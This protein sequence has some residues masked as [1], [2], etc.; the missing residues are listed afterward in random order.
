MNNF[1]LTRSSLCKKSKL[2]F[3]NDNNRWCRLS[4]IVI[5]ALDVTK[6]PSGP[7]YS[8]LCRVRF[9]SPLPFPH[10]LRGSE[11]ERGLVYRA[12][13]RNRVTETATGPHTI[14]AANLKHGT[15]HAFEC[16]GWLCPATF[17]FCLSRHQH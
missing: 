7:R 10:T 15:G 3:N 14:N 16:L 17:I 6:A 12:A 13:A 2:V 1:F 5:C 11:E 8:P 4:Q 9:L